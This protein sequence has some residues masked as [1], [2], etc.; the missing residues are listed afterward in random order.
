VKTRVLEKRASHQPPAH[1]AQQLQRDNRRLE[2]EVAQ[3]EGQLAHL[4]SAAQQA[5]E[6]AIRWKDEARR[7]EAAPSAAAAAEV[8]HAHTL[9]SDAHRALDD[10]NDEIRYLDKLF[11]VHR[12][13][14]LALGHVEPPFPFS[15]LI[16]SQRKRTNRGARVRVAALDPP[17]DQ[18]CWT[19]AKG[20]VL[21]CGST[22]GWNKQ[23]NNN[24]NRRNQDRV[25]S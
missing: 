14:F 12:Q 3:M 15:R 24:P 7:A 6:E 13:Q 8:K 21:A 4:S 11:E 22:P 5:T 9:L 17:L 23:L 2:M 25:S 16:T 1:E 10:R 18:R 20:R 19:N